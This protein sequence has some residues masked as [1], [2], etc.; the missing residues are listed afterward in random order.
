MLLHVVAL[1]FA[2]E[3]LC[4]PEG[5]RIKVA[6]TGAF[7]TESVAPVLSVMQLGEILLGTAFGQP[8]MV[9]RAQ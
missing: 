8:G 9:R 6:R 1:H 7:C 3:S 4:E 5:S 2:I